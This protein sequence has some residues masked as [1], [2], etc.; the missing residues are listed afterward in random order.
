[1]KTSA[2]GMKWAISSL[3]LAFSLAACGGSA[4]P[5]PA[6]PRIYLGT[7]SP[8]D[9]WR[10]T[11]RAS[12]FDAV[13]LTTGHAYSG[14]QS[15]LPSGFLELTITASTDPG[16][17]PPATAHA[18]EVPDTVL[19]ARLAAPGERFIAAVALGACPTAAATYDWVDVPAPTFDARTTSAYGTAVVAPEGG[20]Y[21]ITGTSY[22]LDGTLASPA[23]TDSAT[24]ANG[25]MTLGSGGTGAVTPS[26]AFMFDAGAGAGGG[27][28]LVAPPASLNTAAMAT[29]SYRGVLSKTR[30]GTDITEPVGADPAGGGMVAGYCFTDLAT[31]AR[32]ADPGVTIDFA[33][34]AQPSPGIL[35]FE[36]TDVDGRH[37]FVAAAAHLGGRYMLF[38]VSTNSSPTEPYNVLLVER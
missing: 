17:T 33:G 2:R 21:A 23:F 35:R 5:G 29:R 6:A 14:T 24:C 32:C 4:A 36:L 18:L 30:G 38:A 13:N 3:A 12:S 8:G 19:L 15:P 11:L 9:V 16:V 7:Q 25:Q 28:G 37:D 20:G 31:G 27:I 22:F 1:M 10:W 34:A 26:R